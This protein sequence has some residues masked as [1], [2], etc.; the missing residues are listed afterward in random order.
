MNRNVEIKA[1]VSARTLAV[2]RERAAALAQGPP[3]TLQQRDTF[4]RVPSGRLKLRETDAG[5]AELIFYERPDRPGPKRSSYVCSPCPEPQS[6]LE[7]LRA[8]LGVRG[9]VEKRREVFLVGQAR[10]H[11]DDVR[12]LGTYLELEVVLRKDQ[13]EAEGR[14]VATGI[15]E[16]LDVDTRQLVPVAYIDLLDGLRDQSGSA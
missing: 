15:L 6:L 8:A 1:R 2:L 12:G 4:F 3:E 16:A 7:A 14:A 11:I 13:T 9:V 10:V 5:T